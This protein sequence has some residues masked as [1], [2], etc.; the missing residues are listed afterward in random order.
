M[1]E[2]SGLDATRVEVGLGAVLPRLRQ[3]AGEE[4]FTKAIEQM[5]DTFWPLSGDSPPRDGR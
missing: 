2:R 1:A 4:H 3:A 5:P